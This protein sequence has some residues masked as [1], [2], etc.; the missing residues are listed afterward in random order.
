[1]C[2]R[3]WAENF[4]KAMQLNELYIYI[5]IYIYIGGWAEKFR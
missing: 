4:L 2:I 3:E 5:Y 1:M